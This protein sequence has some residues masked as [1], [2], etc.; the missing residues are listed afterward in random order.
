MELSRQEKNRIYNKNY[1]RNHQEEIRNQKK[2]YRKKNED[3]IKKYRYENCDKAKRY[4][5][6]RRN[7]TA[8]YDKQYYQINKDKVH[9]RTKKWRKDHIDDVRRKRKIYY[10]ENRS[11]IIKQTKNYYKIHKFKKKKYMEKYFKK[12]RDRHNE[13]NIRRF[14]SIEIIEHVDKKKLLEMFS[15]QCAYCDTKIKNNSDTHI[16]HLLPI[17]RFQ[18]IG[19]KAPHSYSNCVPA[20]SECN[21]SKHDKT[22]LEF[23]WST[24]NSG[25]EL[26]L[27]GSN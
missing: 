21:R 18:R 12:N 5:K 2:K 9:R 17:V 13:L 27:I 7:I 10:L 14:R 4:R 23:I 26:S 3:K 6:D 19:K 25:K 11:K 16:D 1:Y 22:P 20:C 15:W 24:L 8:Q